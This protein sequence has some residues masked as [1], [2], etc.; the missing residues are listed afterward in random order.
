MRDL[1]LERVDLAPG[2]LVH[3]VLGVD[4]PFCGMTRATLAL[5]RGDVAAA[6]ALHPLAPFVL[7]AA[8]VLAAI[9]VSG[10]TDRLLV[11]RRPVWL[12][13]AI[14]AVWAARLAVPIP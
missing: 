4:C 5:V 7:S 13:A 10:R 3:A 9:V 2:C 11:G 12:L 8:L 1:C 6:L 14:G